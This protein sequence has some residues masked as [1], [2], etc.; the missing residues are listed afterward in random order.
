[1]LFAVVL[2]VGLATIPPAGGRFAVLAELPI[3]RRWLLVAALVVQIIDISVLRRPPHAVAAGLHLLS[4]ALAGAF[5]LA[6]R[7][8]RGLPTTALGGLLNVVAIAANDGTMPASPSALRLAGIAADHQHFANSAA[9]A[10]ARLGV[11][12]DVFAVPHR[13]GIANVF[14]VGDVVVC[15]GAILLLHAGAGSPWATRRKLTEPLS[16]RRAA[17]GS[18]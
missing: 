3:R 2:A 16:P 9:V 1:M 10:G 12:G 15:C 5:L 7:R 14:S 6:N 11:L 4:Y 17:G 13:F 8:L 18:L